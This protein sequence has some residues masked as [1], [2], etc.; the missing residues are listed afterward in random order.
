[1]VSTIEEL[2]AAIAAATPGTTIAL[3]NGTYAIGVG[4]GLDLAVPGVTLRSQSG[5]AADVVLDGQYVSS[6]ILTIAASDVTV[7][8]VT[9]AH[10]ANVGVGVHA[11]T[12]DVTGVRIY[13][14][15]LLDNPGRAVLIASTIS[16][17]TGPYP[18]GGE[19]ACSHFEHRTSAPDPC[20]VGAMGID[21][22]GVRDW[23]IR[24]NRFDGMACST[25][26]R[27]VVWF[28]A[29]SRDTKIV[30]NVFVG[31]SQNIAIGYTSSAGGRT[32]SDPLPAGC[33]GEPEHRGGLVC[34]NAIAGFGLPPVIGNT[35]FEEG[36]ALWAACDPWVIHN[37]IASP[38]GGE[39]FTNLEYRFPQ[40]FVHLVNNLALLAPTERDAGV[41][42]ATY[43]PSN[44]VYT[45]EGD[46]M[47]AI[48]GD[49][50]LSATATPPAGASIES[51]GLCTVD[52]SGTPRDLTAPDP[53]AFER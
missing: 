2:R 29:G 40:S 24:N 44:A 39:T 1:M 15:H 46:F 28:R 48:G 8:G 4:A 7:A 19:I 53:G 5:N 14:V 6:R 11:S 37:T 30:A 22:A 45:T 17:E 41:A 27:R 38:G 21:G 35:D 3:A 26:S 42:D 50:R 36:I 16:A 12:A 20:G 13:G 23:V 9:L 33:T 49:L 51:L 34:N 10:A 25:M 18:D 32:Y 52:A 47:N 31:S 43:L